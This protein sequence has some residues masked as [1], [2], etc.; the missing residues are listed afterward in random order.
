M[1]GLLRENSVRSYSDVVILYRTNAQSRL[2]EEAFI[3][4]DIPYRLL[5]GT[6]I[7][8]LQEIRDFVAYLRVLSNP[9]DDTA[10]RR[11]VNTPPRGI[12]KKTQEEFEQ[13]CL[14]RQVPL[15]LGLSELLR[16][17]ANVE[18][19]DGAIGIGRA[20][21]QKLAGFAD[22]LSKP[23]KRS[24]SFLSEEEPSRESDCLDT[25][26]TA[27]IEEVGYCDYVE[28]REGN[29]SA[30]SEKV[31]ERLRNIEELVR[32]SSRF[33]NVNRYLE[34]A[35]L[36]VDT[37]QNGAGDADNGSSDRAAAS[38]MTLHGGKG[39]EFGAVF[40]IGAE[41]SVIPFSR[42]GKGYIEEER[43]FL[44]VG[45]KRAKKHLQITWR[46]KK[47]VL[48]GGNCSSPL[49]WR[50]SCRSTPTSAAQCPASLLT[51]EPSSI[52]PESRLFTIASSTTN[53]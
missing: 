34:G 40:I 11:I 29:G 51:P 33:S 47:L 37:M 18:L 19:S 52:T 24:E 46:A 3:Q 28:K 10:F 7:Y 9:A 14:E 50:R 39:L 23:Q 13:F 20:A 16:L 53:P 25:L 44:Y 21:M 41:D 6:K 35:T 49:L 15:V 36:M 43:R 17:Y 2:I 42:G 31:L 26:L 32:A 27:V 45:M 5:S 4:N 8:D 30:A 38:L 22:M 1:K 12:G 48:Q